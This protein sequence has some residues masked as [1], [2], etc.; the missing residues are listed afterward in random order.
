MTQRGD[1]QLPD[2]LERI[3]QA[4][5]EDAA[6]L[7]AKE[8]GGRYLYIPRAFRPTHRLCQLIGEE[9]ARAMWDAIGHG[10]VMVP[11]GPYSGAAARRE[12]AARALDAGKSQPQAAKVAGVHLRTVERIA[13][14][15]RDDD[16]QQG[17]LF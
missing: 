17:K 5:G 10:M 1:Q 8:W 3:A 11:M 15:K 2:I 13:A 7:V 16:D 14:K 9:R 6:L 4:A 12:I